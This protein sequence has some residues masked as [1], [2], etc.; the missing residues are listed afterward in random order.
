MA[1]CRRAPGKTGACGQLG[2]RTADRM[3]VPLSPSIRER[4]CPARLGPAQTARIYR[5]ERR[6][7]WTCTAGSTGPRIT[8]TSQSWT[9]TGG[10]WP[11]AGS[12]TTRPGWPSCSACSPS[13]A[14]PPRTRSR[15]PSRRPAACWSRAC[16]PPGARSTPSTR[17]RLP[18]TGTGTRSR[19]ANP[20]TATRSCWPACCAPTCTRTGRC[21]PTPS[22]PRPS[23]SWPAPSKTPS[24]TAPPRTTGSVRTCAN[25]S[26]PS[27]PPSPMPAAASPGPRPAPCWPPPLP[28]PTPP[29]SP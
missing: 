16:G 28:R 22:W 12:A 17:C 29:S 6:N 26:P 18:A 11:A 27:W 24:G 23:R 10:C 21:P 1:G 25:T 13:T 8:T 4:A 9:G 7:A 3:A 14:T 15:W 20:T 19:A 2:L 5:G